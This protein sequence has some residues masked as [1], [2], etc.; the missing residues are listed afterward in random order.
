MA[1]INTKTGDFNGYQELSKEQAE[2]N[3]WEYEV[4]QGDTNLILRLLNGEW[5]NEDFLVVAPNN[6]IEPTNS[7][8]IIHSSP[9]V[10]ESN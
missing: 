7:K 8:N 6:Q 2:K 3:D 10:A 1:Y 5:H 4:I 9:F